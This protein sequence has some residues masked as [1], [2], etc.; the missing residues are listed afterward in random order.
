[1]GQENGCGDVVVAVSYG[2]LPSV[3][4]MGERPNPLLPF[5]CGSFKASHT[6]SFV[7]HMGSVLLGQRKDKACVTVLTL[8][9]MDFVSR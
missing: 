2:A 9:N 3:I 4:L 5:M 6:V 7:F 1:M 8:E